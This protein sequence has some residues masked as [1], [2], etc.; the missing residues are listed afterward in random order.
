MD[1]QLLDWE[2]GVDD[3]QGWAIKDISDSEC[4]QDSLKILLF[5]FRHR[6]VDNLIILVTITR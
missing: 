6:S 3:L 5:Q 4:L 1:K 2:G